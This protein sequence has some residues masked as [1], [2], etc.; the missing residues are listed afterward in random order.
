MAGAVISLDEV[1]IQAGK[2]RLE[3]VS[4]LVPE[5][6]FG[7]LMGRTGS[8]K[9]TI[10]EAICGLR[11]IRAGRIVVSHRDVTHAPPAARGIGYV[12]QDGA[13]FTTKT[14]GANL[15]FPLDV[16]GWRPARKRERVE[17][18]ADLLGITHLLD[19][20]T[21]GLSGGE[22]QR[23]SLGRALAF[24]PGTLL[25]DEPLS[26]LDDE[27][28]RQMYDLIERVRE[29]ENV[30]CLHVTHSHA[31]AMRLG[32]CFFSIE[33]G[34]VVAAGREKFPGAAVESSSAEESTPW[35]PSIEEA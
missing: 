24:R 25:L 9:T 5:R 13:I 14:V 27:T 16:R 11:A 19:R 23:V 29:H 26:A 33:G 17:E 7:V 28:R 3:N 4:L 31:E 35:A 12:P 30:T 22:R 21:H 32:D 15:S 6:R 8:G 20:G 18:L 2:F 10:L 1:S 34:A